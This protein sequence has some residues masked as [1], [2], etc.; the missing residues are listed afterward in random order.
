MLMIYNTD[1]TCIDS[2]DYYH[3]VAVR[4]QVIVVSTRYNVV[5][6][7]PRTH[8]GAVLHHGALLREAKLHHL[9]MISASSA[10]NIVS[11]YPACN[12]VAYS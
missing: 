5:G 6:Y 1:S 12:V 3:T 10:H 9:A 2:E 4:V 8:A 7:R 11:I